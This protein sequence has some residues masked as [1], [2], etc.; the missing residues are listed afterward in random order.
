MTPAEPDPLERPC[1]VLQPGH[2]NGPIEVDDWAGGIPQDR[3][4][5]P[6][7]RL[8]RRWFSSLWLIPLGI[9]ALVL[10]IAVVRELARQPWFA[11]FIARYPG[12]SDSYVQPVSTGFP[13]V[14]ALAAL[15]EPVVH[16]VHHQG[17]LADPG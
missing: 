6:S 10:S 11:D 9:V 12:T 2:R 13:L 7:V 17:G 8:G 5:L 3:A 15:P 14:A 1:S 16:D 4:E